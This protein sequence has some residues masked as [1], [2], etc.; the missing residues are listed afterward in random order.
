MT[1]LKNR[2]ELVRMLADALNSANSSRQDAVWT[3]EMVADVCISAL[4]AAGLAVVPVEPT[5]EMVKATSL[6]YKPAPLQ[7]AS[8]RRSYKRML[9]SSPF[10][11]EDQ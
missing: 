11:K 6:K 9:A 1:T 7:Q 10:R 8:A 2:E 3:T 5:E 4:E